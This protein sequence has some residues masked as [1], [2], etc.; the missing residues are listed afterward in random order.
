MENKKS[1]DCVVVTY[2]RLDLLKECVQAIEKQTYPV[3]NFFIIDNCSNDNTWNYLKSIRNE[4]IIPIHLDKNL[5]GAG[6]FN[7]G[8]K[9]FINKST[10]DYVWIMD[11]DTIPSFTALE[12]MIKKSNVSPK[13]GFLCGN[14]RWKDKSVAVMNIPS[15]SKNWNEYSE[16]GITK[17]NSASF[18]SIMFPRDVVYKV[19]YPITDFFIWGDDV[20][21]TLRITHDYSLDGFM[22][23]DSL[24]E[25]KI[26]NNIATD[27]IQEE[28]LGRIKRYYLAQ[29]N[30][31]FYLKKHSNKKEVFKATIRQG[32]KLP[33]NAVLKSKNHKVYRAWVSIKGTVA[34]LFF[35]PKIEKAEK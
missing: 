32:I 34:G 12:K 8:M 11:D 31:I 28:S 30:T 22:V 6:G 25:H 23:N 15:P 2:N 27:L 18:V 16:Y 21:Y 26:K 14:V 4:K 17:V 20:E 5:G 7:A 35:K 3:S 33:V 19:G 29:R 13:L 9:A 24:V 1:V 10:S